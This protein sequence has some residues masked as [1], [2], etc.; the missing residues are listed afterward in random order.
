[1]V[2]IDKEWNFCFKKILIVFLENNVPQRT[3]CRVY[4][5]DEEVLGDQL[6]HGALL[7]LQPGHKLHR[8][9]LHEDYLSHTQSGF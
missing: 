7:Q 8:G 9:Q 2:E 5:E 4:A 6:H 3:E 1:M